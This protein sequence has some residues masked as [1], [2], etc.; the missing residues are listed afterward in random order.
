CGSG[1]MVVGRA[2]YKDW[3]ENS[4]DVNQQTQDGI[5][6]FVDELDRWG[7]HDR[8]KEVDEMA[9]VNERWSRPNGYNTRRS[10]FWRVIKEVLRKVDQESAGSHEWDSQWASHLAWSNLYKISAGGNP[11]GYLKKAQRQGCIDMLKAELAEYRPSKVLFL[12][13][14]DWAKPFLDGIE[15]D[16]STRPPTKYVEASG[17]ISIPNHAACVFVV[18]KHPQRKP[19]SPWVAQV[20]GAFEDFDAG[21]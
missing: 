13:G 12:T 10:A 6:K 18:A 19:E 16:V 20:L 9:W 4:L 1:L 14:K 11:T 15:H 8:G 3:G 21:N 5:R 17:T 2:I 7:N